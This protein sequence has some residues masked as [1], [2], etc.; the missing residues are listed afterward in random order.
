MSHEM[1][2]VDTINRLVGD[3]NEAR[4]A[5]TDVIK[6]N[7]M[8]F[9]HNAMVFVP[10]HAS[11][12]LY[13]TVSIVAAIT[14]G[15]MLKKLITAENALQDALVNL[16]TVSSSRDLYLSWWDE[17][18]D[19]RIELG[20]KFSSLTIEYEGLEA[21]NETLI[22]RNVELTQQCTEWEEE[23]EEVRGE[24]D[25]FESDR[26]YW[27]S[28]AREFE[29]SRDSLEDELG[30]AEERISTLEALADTYKDL[31]SEFESTPQLKLVA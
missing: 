7:T 8:E 25:D 5:V 22:E 27:H 30:E 9:A 24:R 23:L 26:D 1:T 19:K 3:W 6:A 29:S 15:I 12:L 10:N 28:E 18:F 13:G 14:L 21:A 11:E 4:I 2:V 16:D 31:V 17:E 20:N